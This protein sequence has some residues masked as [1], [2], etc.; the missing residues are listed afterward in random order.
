MNP[1]SR[2]LVL[3][4]LDGWGI[5]P[6]CEGNAVCQARTPRLDDL[7][8][9]YPSTRIGASG[10]DV[11][12]PD[13]QMGNSEVGHLNIGAGRIV[14]QD[15]TRISRSIEEGDFF[16]NPALTDAL[17]KV[18]AGDGKLHLMGLLSDGGVHSHIRH[19][20]ALVDLA[21]RQGIQKVCVHAFLDGRDTPPQSGAGYLA[22]LERKLADFGIGRVATVMGRFY[23]MDRDNRW[24]RIE[25]AYL[26]MTEGTGAEFSSSA[27]AIARAY[28]NGQTDEFVEPC[29]IRGGAYPGTVDDGDGI[30]FFNF[31]AD[32][33]REITRAFT[34]KDFSGFQRR[35][36]PDLADY[37]CLT[38][39]DATFSLPVAFPPES[40]SNILGE[41]IAGAGLRQLRIA[42]TEK[43]AHVTFFFNGGNETSFAGED[44]VLIPSPQEVKTYDLK[45]AMSATA[46]TDEMVARVSSGVYDFI[47]LNFANPDMVGHSGNL[48]AAV[49]AMEAVDHCVGRVVDTVLAAGG[50][51]LVTADH[52][53]CEQMIDAAGKPQTAHTSNPVPLILVASDSPAARLREGILADIAPTLLELMG[54]SQPAEMTGRSLLSG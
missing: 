5:N 52:G 25:K 32:R 27:E 1:P 38:E 37:V 48:K 30:V 24:D 31:R 17:A 46:V 50:T 21:R 45:P 19:L 41:V 47:V 26:A 7:L 4:I 22:D 9:H 13:G 51:L 12:L 28:D 6:S 42:E 14:Y 44:R 2:P 18:R 11:G 8:Q 34:Q 39:Y 33:A 16:T 35:K 29:V 49:E 40:Y 23:A 54:L 15:L 20:Y 53:N 10:A 36:T 3:M 43:Y